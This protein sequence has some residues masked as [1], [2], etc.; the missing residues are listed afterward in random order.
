MGWRGNG[1]FMLRGRGGSMRL[2]SSKDLG[3]G[4]GLKFQRRGGRLLGA[5]VELVI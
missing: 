4:G 1:G 5:A 3:G 2:W